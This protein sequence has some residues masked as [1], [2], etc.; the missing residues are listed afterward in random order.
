MLISRYLY[1]IISLK[2]IQIFYQIGNK[3]VFTR[4]KLDNYNKY[5]GKSLQKLFLTCEYNQNASCN[6]ST[7]VDSVFTFL[8]QEYDFKNEIN[9]N[10]LSNGKLW[11]YNLQ[12]LDYIND[13]RIDISYRR[14]ILRLNSIAL[15]N[16]D[17]K[18][19]PY[20]VSLRIN[21][22]LI[23]NSFF[24]IN[25]VN[26]E[27]ALKLQID[28]LER[29]VEYHILGNH[30]LENYISLFLASYLINDYDLNKNISDKFLKELEEQILDDGG[31]FERSPMY[32]SIILYRLL[33]CIDVIENNGCFENIILLNQL[34]EMCGYMLGWLDA[35]SYKDG[36]WPLVNDSANN[37][38]LSKVEL[39]KL[40]CL[41]KVQKLQTSLKS[42]GF[43]KLKIRQFE[44]LIN[45]GNINPKYQPGHTHSDMMSFYLWKGNKQFIVDTGVSTYECNKDR[46]FERS[47][48]AHNTI[49]LNG[50][51]QSDVWGSFRIGKKSKLILNI[52]KFNMLSAEINNMFGL[53]P[54]TKHQRN[55]EIINDKLHISD[56]VCGEKIDIVNR[57]HL[58]YSVKPI[59]DGN[60]IYFDDFVIKYCSGLKSLEL[61]TYEQAIGFNVKKNAY[62]VVA[63]VDNVSTFIISENI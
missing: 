40:A 32:H 61:D 9:W 21:N 6:K 55:F 28:F 1:T 13:N 5:L 14:T 20:P 59:I 27:R 3:I 7:I 54:N 11:N 53:S 15:L 4:R 48:L 30:L 51:S 45:L 38:C 37:I 26:V 56:F 60:T 34:K 12:Y 39:E 35:F 10:Y 33:L 23:F 25:D 18:L 29:N 50:N 22:I 2:P 47:T 36:S 42:S 41:L 24:G 8:N 43:R 63:C 52:D 58:D 44:V 16:G 62:K 46:L 17:L 49:T 31:H 57:I 19:E